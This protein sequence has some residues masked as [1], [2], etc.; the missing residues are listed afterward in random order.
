MIILFAVAC[1]V[2]LSWEGKLRPR[3][4]VELIVWMLSSS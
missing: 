2:G 4:G 1:L 3:N